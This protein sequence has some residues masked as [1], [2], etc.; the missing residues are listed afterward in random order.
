[1]EGNLNEH[2]SS[3]APISQNTAR[4]ALLQKFGRYAAVAPAATMILLPSESDAGQ[5]RNRRRHR[6]RR[7]GKN[8]DYH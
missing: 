6:R 3:P 8:N 1:M 5:R 4:R 7:G 2:S